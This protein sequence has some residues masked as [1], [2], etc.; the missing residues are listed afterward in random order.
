MSGCVVLDA[1]GLEQLARQRPSGNFRA[2]LQVAWERDRDV[3]VPAV[4]CAE[5]CRG[6]ARTRAVE[7][8]LGRHDRGRGQRPAV[9]VADTDFALARQVGAILHASHA[10]TADIVDAHVVA[11][12]AAHG[13][14]LVVTSDSGDITRLAAAVPAVRIATSPPG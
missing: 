5:V 13:G 12:S 10:S 8:A 2:L 14:G 6:A 4:V 1:A 11:I 7:A 9:L 3:L